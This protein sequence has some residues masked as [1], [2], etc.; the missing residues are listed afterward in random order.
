MEKG[1]TSLCKGD[2][3]IL[4]SKVIGSPYYG[5]EYIK[6]RSAGGTSQV[7]SAPASLMQDPGLPPSEGPSVSDYLATLYVLAIPAA[8][9]PKAEQPG[10]YTTANALPATTAMATRTWPGVETLVREIAGSSDGLYVVTGPLFEASI[11]P[12]LSSGS[13]FPT[14]IY[15]AIYDPIAQRSG[16]YICTN[17]NRPLCEVSSIAA[18]R[19][20]SDIDPFPAVSEEIKQRFGAF[21]VPMGFV[22]APEAVPTAGVHAAPGWMS[23]APH[24]TTNFPY[25]CSQLGISQENGSQA[26]HTA[27]QASGTPNNYNCTFDTDSGDIWGEDDDYPIGNLFDY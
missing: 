11:N 6:P 7:I 17:S 27:K 22:S 18:L 10:S 1:T 8:D 23:G 20:R 25:A 16:A 21:P 12:S 9:L 3:D 15:K 5:S 26:L 24:M 19:A 14:S 13:L 2:Y 4:Y